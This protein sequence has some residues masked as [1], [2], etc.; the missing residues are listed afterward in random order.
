MAG[1]LGTGSGI[2]QSALSG[3]QRASGLETQRENTNE[4]LKTAEQNQKVTTTV[5][6]ATSGAMIGGAATSWSGPGMIVGTLVG[7]GVGYL[8]SEVF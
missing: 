6:G 5:S 1:V 4:Q 2:R 8:L 3:M 7:A